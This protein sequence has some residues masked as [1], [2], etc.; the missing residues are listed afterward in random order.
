[1]KTLLRQQVLRAAG[2][3][4]RNTEGHAGCNKKFNSLVAG[5]SEPQYGSQSLVG[6]HLSQRTSS[7]LSLAPWAAPETGQIE[8]TCRERVIKRK[9]EY[10]EKLYDKTCIGCTGKSQPHCRPRC[11]PCTAPRSCTPLKISINGAST[12]KSKLKLDWN[13]CDQAVFIV[14]PSGAVKVKMLSKPFLRHMELP[15]FMNGFISFGTFSPFLQTKTQTEG[16]PALPALPIYKKNWVQ[17]EVGV[18]T[19][20]L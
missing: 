15:L 6:T 18:K 2:A 4:I 16:S 5:S 3:D 12:L 1:M 14:I 11:T 13:C 20:S 17:G 19:L 8:K 7:A 9:A 10:Q